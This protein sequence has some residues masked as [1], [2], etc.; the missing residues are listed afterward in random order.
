VIAGAL[1]CSK[2]APDIL[3]GVGRCLERIGRAG[4]WDRQG[5]IAPAGPRPMSSPHSAVSWGSAGS[6]S[7]PGMHGEGS[8]RALTQVHA[9][10]LSA[11]SPVRPIRWTSSCGS[12]A[13]CERV[14]RRVHRTIRAA[15]A[16]RL[17]VERERMRPLPAWLPDSDRRHVV[18]VPQQPYV[19]IAR[20]DYLIAPRFAGRRCPSRGSATRILILVS[21]CRTRDLASSGAVTVTPA[22]AA[23]LSEQN[24]RSTASISRHQSTLFRCIRSDR[25][26]GADRLR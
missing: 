20:N 14:N 25:N 2:E 6:S 10:E 16:E 8:A 17:V 18:R 1:I 19:R 4:G 24:L 11:G 9:L 23:R 7:T 26:G 22:G 3:W 13:G 12:M 15:P 5:A 21:A